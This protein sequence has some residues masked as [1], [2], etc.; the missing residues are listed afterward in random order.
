MTQQ[1]KVRLTLS[2]IVLAA[3]LLAVA[4]PFALKTSAADAAPVLADTSATNTYYSGNYYNNLNTNLTGT[5]FRTELYNLISNPH[6]NS[7][8]DGL[9]TVYKTSD[10][11]PNRNGNILWFYTGTSTSYNGSMGSSAGTTNREHVWPK[12]GGKAFTPIESEAGSD[13]HHL[14]PT[15]ATLNSTRGEKDFD[16]V[17]QTSS[18][19]V[20]EAG[21]K[22]YGSSPDGLCYSTS[23]SF[24]PAKGYRGATARILFYVQVRWGDKNSLRFVDTVGTSGKT[25]GKISTLLKWHLEEPPTEEEIRRNEVVFGLQNNRNPFIDHPEYAEMIYCYDGQTYNNA[26]KAVVESHG[27]GYMS[28]TPVVPPTPD[29]TPTQF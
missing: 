20:S 1:R 2:I 28:G 4:M 26:L 21:K 29:E 24:Y 6:K 16:E 18:N 13:A 19:I 15:D 3:L 5:A 14:R 23:T 7:T 27:G 8:Y 12:R 9:K 17:P 10:A 11:D 22:N 25:L